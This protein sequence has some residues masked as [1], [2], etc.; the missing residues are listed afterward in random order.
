[1]GLEGLLLDDLNILNEN[2]LEYLRVYEYLREMPTSKEEVLAILRRAPEYI[3]PDIMSDIDKNV[4][5]NCQNDNKP[6]GISDIP[7][8]DNNYRKSNL[9][10]E[11]CGVLFSIPKVLRNFSTDDTLEEAVFQ[12]LKRNRKL[13]VWDV[14]AIR[15]EIKGNPLLYS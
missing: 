12:A 5:S 3:S 10:Y 13:T 2:N 9:T 4:V 11:V 15:S 14:Q 1:M 6:T 8:L 7:V